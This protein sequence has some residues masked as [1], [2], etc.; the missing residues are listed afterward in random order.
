[1]NPQ[2]LR[3]KDERWLLGLWWTGSETRSC[4]EE[5][6]PVSLFTTTPTPG[7]FHISHQLNGHIAESTKFIPN[8]LPLIFLFIGVWIAGV[9]LPAGED[10]SDGCFTSSLVLSVS[11]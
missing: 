3:H 11:L 9:I 5:P 1:M 4:K 10:F 7:S 8:G 2:A 6:F